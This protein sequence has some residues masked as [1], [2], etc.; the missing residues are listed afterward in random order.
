MRHRSPPAAEVVGTLKTLRLHNDAL[1]APSARRRHDWG[2][3]PAR[4]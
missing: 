1:G 4:V 3:T 2:L